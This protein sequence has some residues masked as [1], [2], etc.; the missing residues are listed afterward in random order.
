[1]YVGWI[2]IVHKYIQ[3]HKHMPVSLITCGF[4]ICEFTY[5]LWFTG[6]HKKKKKPLM[7]LESRVPLHLPWDSEKSAPCHPSWNAVPQVTPPFPLALSWSRLHVWCNGAREIQE[8]FF[9][10]FLWNFLFSL[11]K[12]SVTWFLLLDTSH[13]PTQEVNPEKQGRDGKHLILEDIFGLLLQL[14]ADANQPTL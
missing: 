6:N 8:S 7:S 2:I 13:L 10:C 1:M 9:W 3:V 11:P 14:L 4:C 12:L 5:S